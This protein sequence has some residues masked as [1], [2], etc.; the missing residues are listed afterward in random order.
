MKLSKTVLSV[1][2]SL[3][4]TLILGSLV[5]QSVKAD[6]TVQSTGNI[7]KTDQPDSV[8]QQ[9]AGN[10]NNT[11]QKVT[12]TQQSA[13]TTDNTNQKNL[14]A[15]QP[16]GNINST[17]QVNSN[18]QQ[19]FTRASTA[20]PQTA[21]VNN[22]E[23][24]EP[25]QNDEKTQTVN[26]NFDCNYPGGYSAPIVDSNGNHYTISGTYNTGDTI[27]PSSLADQINTDLHGYYTLTPDQNA[28]T[29]E[30]G[31]NTYNLQLTPTKNLTIDYAIKSPNT[32]DQD[33]KK[34][35][36]I[37]VGKKSIDA[38]SKQ[39]YFTN[40]KNVPINE[41]IQNGYK[42][43][44]FEFK[45]GTVIPNTNHDLPGYDGTITFTYDMIPIINKIYDGDT[46]NLTIYAIFD[47]PTDQTLT[48]KHVDTQGNTI[49][50]STDENISGYK[51]GD[52]IEDPY[53]L[54]NDTKLDGYTYLRTVKPYTVTN[55]NEIDLV[56][57]NNEENY[58]TVNYID[59]DTGKT[60]HTDYVPGNSGDT[61]D[62]KDISGIENFKKYKMS[63][64]STDGNYTYDI[65]ED[66]ESTDIP[67]EVSKFK[68]NLVQTLPN[69]MV[70]KSTTSADYGDTFNFDAIK[71]LS[72][73]IT[74][75][76]GAKVNGE[77]FGGD[78][79]LDD[80]NSYSNVSDI[81]PISG[82]ELVN[83][84]GDI[85]RDQSID[86]NINY[87]SSINT[88]NVIYQ[89]TDN[90][91]VDNV[92][93]D[94]SSFKDVSDSD[95]SVTT[96]IL[97]DLVTTNIPK[98]YELV[99]SSTPY[100]MGTT[101]D[102]KIN[103]IANVKKVTTPVT[104]VNPVTPGGGNSGNENTGN[105]GNTDNT[106]DSDNNNGGVTN[107]KETIS[108]QPGSSNIAIYDNNGKDT[109]KTIAS[110]GDWV[111]DKKVQVNGKTYYRIATDQW[112][113]SDDTYVYYQ[114]PMN[115]QTYS[116]SPQKLVNSSD[117]DIS[118]YMLSGDSDWHADRFIYLNNQKYYRVSTNEWISAKD[119][120]EYQTID[121][122]V[123]PSKNA[124]LFDDRGNFVKVSPSYSLKTDKFATINGVKM[125]RVATN[126]WLPAT[127]VK[128]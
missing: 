4:S 109:G 22:Q 47:I 104:P 71:Y 100:T 65:K 111:T 12:A 73:D 20:V 119:V 15:Q 61:V 32:S 37:Y 86:M 92:S 10:A 23:T 77:M 127:D 97:D 66:N 112:I 124:K 21:T 107:V 117:K 90:K 16:A 94:I 106:G 128:S 110:N 36:T 8:V 35:L 48:I 81:F 28:I 7:N 46:T 102:N 11:A 67:V 58:L 101:T 80:L 59:K 24:E 51:T 13:V 39:S 50:G 26:I 79:P 40:D 27:D 63:D 29:V 5:N 60:V 116:D 78:Y 114:S 98:D 74:T 14:V 113:S 33:V 93:E 2:I 125:Y 38:N 9:P 103:L 83:D 99:D 6:Q 43:N 105:S 17:N 70:F 84:D 118:T 108:I 42:F 88:F 45:D 49:S 68:F 1:S 115:I 89:T 44:H 122:V 55:K 41:Q 121:Q 53:T 57:R 18:I 3:C 120:L 31:T 25:S 76:V 123:S 75:V 126:Q 72:D 64:T 69:G 52:I 85:L 96:N 54:D 56:Y 82:T 30:K 95:G 62:I 87:N 19:S 91:A 34:G